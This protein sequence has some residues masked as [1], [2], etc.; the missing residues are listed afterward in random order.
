MKIAGH[1]DH[2]CS[3]CLPGFMRS[4]VS[5]A[6]ISRRS[7]AHDS[8]VTANPIGPRSAVQIMRS[9]TRAIFSAAAHAQRAADYLHKPA[10]EA[11]RGGTGRR[12]GGPV[13]RHGPAPLHRDRRPPL[14]VAR[15]GGA[16]PRPGDAGRAAAGAVRLAR[17]SPARRRARRRGAL[18]LAEPVHRAGAEPLRRFRWRLDC[19]K[20]PGQFPLFEHRNALPVRLLKSTT[21][22]IIG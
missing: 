22:P 5:T 21:D 7:P 10:T 8:R 12:I 6:A 11:D 9:D 13:S 16:A 17:R 2:D 3:Q 19:Q 20:S 18:Q 1:V 15:P 4:C 14:S